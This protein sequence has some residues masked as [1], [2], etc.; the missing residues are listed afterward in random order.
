MRLRLGLLQDQAAID[1][2][3]AREAKEAQ[4]KKHKHETPTVKTEAEMKADEAAAAKKDD[5]G[6]ERAKSTSQSK[7]KIRPLSEAKA[8]DSGATFISETFLFAVA[9]STIVFEAWR[10]RRKENTRREDVA[11]K[12]RNLEEQDKAKWELLDELQREVDMLR[13]GSKGKPASSALPSA[14]GKLAIPAIT[15]ST[16]SV[17]TPSKEKATS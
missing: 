1:R 7:P 14:Q 9:L 5:A 11:E 13:S 15:G 17:I 8:I 3:I 16:G 2:Q 6:M 10:S 4:I 12:L